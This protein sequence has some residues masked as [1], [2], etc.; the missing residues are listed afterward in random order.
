M[1]IV[2]KK[3][4]FAPPTPLPELPPVLPLPDDA[5]PD[6]LQNLVQDA[7]YRIGC[8]PDFV[9]VAAITAL[10]SVLGRKRVIRGKLHD[11]WVVVP[12]LWGMLIG[13]PASMKSP[14]FR[15]A[16]E[17][18]EVLEAKQLELHNDCLREHE[19]EVRLQKMQAA[20]QERS[21]KN[22]LK[23]GGMDAA[24]DILMK[25]ESISEEAPPRPRLVVNDATIQKLQELLVTNTN[26][27][28]VLRDE[29][30]GLIARL[31]CEEYAEDRSFLLLAHGGRSKYVVDRIGRGTIVLPSVC[32]SILGGVQ[33]ARVSKLVRGAVGGHS[34]DGLL[35]R[36]QLVTW[37]DSCGKWRW[38]DQ[39]PCAAAKEAYELIFTE[40]HNLE[41]M[42]LPL[43]MEDGA[44]Q[45]FKQWHIEMR[46][47][48]DSGD[49]A[50]A[51]AAHLLKAPEMVLS[52]AL[53]FQ[54]CT[55][56]KSDHVDNHAMERALK[57]AKYLKSHAFRLYHSQSSSEVVAAKRL[58]KEKG[59]L[60]FLFT[61]RDIYRRNWEGLQRDGTTAALALLVDYGHLHE[62]VEL[63]GG[64]PTKSYQW[65]Y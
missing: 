45:L 11:D 9:A 31:E 57:W 49:L 13:P 8:P 64:R 25:I 50:P 17:P 43:V 59:K 15:S 62:H 23:A 14:A 61:A 58:I 18:L 30:G 32:V 19:L 20:S 35:Q 48:V 28:L 2:T 36:F 65:T 40:F 55:N 46:D 24:R 47:E 53:I 16:L 27:L 42:D 6:V 12:N 21:A 37:P 56:V 3:D 38:K 54:L 10:S 39:Q 34:D 7:A 29:L 1:L 33:P 4:V 5:L 52:I 44:Y 22:A 60:T 26:G 63:T 41:H 51:M